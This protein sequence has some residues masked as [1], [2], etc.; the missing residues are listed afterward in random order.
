VWTRCSNCYFSGNFSCFSYS[1]MALVIWN[2]TASARYNLKVGRPRAQAKLIIRQAAVKSAVE[3]LRAKIEQKIY[4]IGKCE[5]LVN[6]RLGQRSRYSDW[7]LA[8]RTRG[9]NSRPS[10]VK[11]YLFSTSPRSVLG[12]TQ[13]SIQWTPEA[14]S[15]GVKRPGREAN[16]SP[17]TSIEVKKTWIYTSTPPYAF[18]ALII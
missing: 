6:S 15:P 18:M 12:P 5:F 7:L 13:P 11:Y 1:G 2:L 14:F 17:P 4:I 8:G 16:H 3:D 9:Q 10:R